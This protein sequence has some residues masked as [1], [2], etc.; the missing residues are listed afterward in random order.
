MDLSSFIQSDRTE[1]YILKYIVSFLSANYTINASLFAF[2]STN[3]KI[4][5]SLLKIAV[6]KITFR[7]QYKLNFYM[8]LLN[9]ILLHHQ[10]QVEWKLPLSILIQRLTVYPESSSTLNLFQSLTTLNL[11]SNQIGDEG[12]RHLS[13][14]L[15]AQPQ[16]FQSLTTLNLGGNRIGSEGMRH[17]SKA[18]QVQPQAFQ[19][20]T[21]LNLDRYQIG[22]EGMRDICQKLCKHN[23]KL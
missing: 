6:D 23:R 15:Q 10:V 2:I 14:A 20:L 4:R 21:T 12:M 8:D 19:S 1:R 17:L 3:H 9:D 16:A 18:L 5:K 7:N 22:A 13:E 11:G